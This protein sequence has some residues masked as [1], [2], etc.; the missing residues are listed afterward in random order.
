MCRR[1][2]SHTLKHTLTHKYILQFHQSCNTRRNSTLN[3]FRELDLREVSL[4]TTTFQAAVAVEEELCFI[5]KGNTNP[6]L[7]IVLH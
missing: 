4:F 1:T 6:L 5:T 2:Q 3:V 7:F